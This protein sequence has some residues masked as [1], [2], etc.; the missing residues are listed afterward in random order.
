MRGDT[1]GLNGHDMTDRAAYVTVSSSRRYANGQ[2]VETTSSSTRYYGSREDSPLSDSS[3][4]GGAPTLVQK[5]IERLYGGRITSVTSPDREVNGGSEVAQK[6]NSGG[7]F[8]KRF[9]ISKKDRSTEK[10][11]QKKND[12]GTS[13]L[14]FKPLKVPAVFRLLRPEF[15]E[16]LKSN[17]CQIPNEQTSPSKLASKS[18]ERLIPIQ[19]ETSNGAEDIIPKTV[20]V[21]QT[22][23]GSKERIIPIEITKKTHEENEK[24]ESSVKR[25]PVKPALPAKP[26]SPPPP[27][28]HDVTSPALVSQVINTTNNNV[29]K[30]SPV[31]EPE[32]IIIEKEPEVTP[33]NGHGEAHAEVAELEP[34]HV[35]EED[36]IEEYE[37]VGGVHQPVLLHTILEEDNEST[38]S[39]SQLSLARTNSNN[40]ANNA[41]NVDPAV[42]MMP[43]KEVHDGHY[44]I[45]VRP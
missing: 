33:S 16:Q 26:L 29:T 39:G 17:S 4:G 22:T 2:I 1:N 5:Q 12:N 43:E 10:D 13:P 8:A 28:P 35:D 42:M 23:N 41:Q 14:D 7:F 36:V 40:N 37:S 32:P 21:I 11:E 30:S 19:T 24:E 27:K 15:R 18:K 31:R 38:A 45:K 20:T 44:F 3:E 25:S 34:V 6:K 9:G